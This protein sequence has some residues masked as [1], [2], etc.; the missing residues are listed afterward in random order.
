MPK[1]NHVLLP[2]EAILIDFHYNGY[3]PPHYLAGC[4]FELSVQFEMRYK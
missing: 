4:S 1:I 3:V 2:N